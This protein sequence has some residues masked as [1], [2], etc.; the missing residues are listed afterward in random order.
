MRAI[1]LVIGCLVLSVACQS[2]P[3]LQCVLSAAELSEARRAVHAYFLHE[4]DAGPYYNELEA[5]EDR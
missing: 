5:V 1:S 4:V 3:A 2:R